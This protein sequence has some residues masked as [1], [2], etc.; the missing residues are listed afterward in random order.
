MI[1]IDIKHL[2]MCNANR[3]CCGY[4]NKPS[5]YYRTKITKKSIMNSDT[6]LKDVTNRNAFL[7][8][9]M[10]MLEIGCTTAKNRSNDIKT[11]V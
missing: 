3:N 11:S 5:Y 7:C 2:T 4:D 10:E 6:L 9:L 1:V 8:V